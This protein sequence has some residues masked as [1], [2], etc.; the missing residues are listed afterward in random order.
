MSAT[1]KSAIV[2]LFAA[3]ALVPAA[4]AQAP[5]E[6]ASVRVAYGDLNMSSRA[7]GEI[8]L[9]R[10]NAAA[11]K[12]CEKVTV[13]SPLTPQAVASCKHE[14]IA[15]T[16]RQLNMATLTAAWEGAPASTTVAAR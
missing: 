15:N 3:A 6:S 13:A 5:A 14:T 10:I 7:G 11:R 12:A 8:L 2:S 16:V 1:F 4:L 9:S